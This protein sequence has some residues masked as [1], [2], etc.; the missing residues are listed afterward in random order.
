MSG[1]GAPL[2]GASKSY[3]AD[4]PPTYASLADA[5]RA[6]LEQEEREQAAQSTL[7]RR[8]LL[9]INV[10]YLVFAVVV[11]GLVGVTTRASNEGSAWAE[12]IPNGALH[13]LTAAA[14]VCASCMHLHLRASTALHPTRCALLRPHLPDCF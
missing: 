11:A 8:F 1:A 7:P 10:V 4:E 13:A 3:D 9:C 5:R 12:M 14:F 2:L 6:L